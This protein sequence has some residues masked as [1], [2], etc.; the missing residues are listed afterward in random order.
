MNH[1]YTPPEADLSEKSRLEETYEPQIFSMKGRLGRLRYIVYHTLAAWAYL[2]VVGVLVVMFAMVF[3]F[4]AEKS[5]GVMAAMVFLI[6]LL[7]IPAIA[8][9]F[10]FAKRRLNDLNQSGWL[11]V[12]TLV[13]FVNLAFYLYLVFAPGTKGS[14]NYGPAPSENQKWVKIFTGVFVTLSLLS[15]VFL[16]PQMVKMNE[17]M[18]KMIDSKMP[19]NVETPVKAD[20]NLPAKELPVPAESAA[21]VMP[22]PE[23]PATESRATEAPTHDSTSGGQVSPPNDLGGGGSPDPTRQTN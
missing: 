17:M 19:D 6:L 12:L 18:D 9:S 5:A 13:P 10:I 21:P 15:L 4:S 8:I 7:Y 14:N 22:A 3:G 1:P 11:S 2:A 23:S 16:Y 20:T